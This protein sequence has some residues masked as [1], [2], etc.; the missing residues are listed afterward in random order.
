M[1]DQHHQSG[2]LCS[3]S[4]IFNALSWDWWREL[5][6]CDWWSEL[7]TAVNRRCWGVPGGMGS[8]VR[9]VFSTLSKRPLV[10]T[11]RRAYTWRQSP[12]PLPLTQH[13][14]G[15][16]RTRSKGS[17]NG[18]GV[19]ERT[20]CPNGSSICREGSLIAP[21]LLS[22]RCAAPSPRALYCQGPAGLLS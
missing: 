12:Q 20:G 4:P 1:S 10:G 13:Q 7:S 2:P 18:E 21:S 14:D 5:A 9:G 22:N 15:A 3:W 6:F 11:C 19:E 8:V 17:R 16:P